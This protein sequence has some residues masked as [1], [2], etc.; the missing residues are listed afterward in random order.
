MLTGENEV[1]VELERVNGL[2]ICACFEMGTNMATF[3]GIVISSKVKEDAVEGNMEKKNLQGI[4]WG[5]GLLCE[6]MSSQ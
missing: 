3:W 5:L 1:V 6:L 4:E 2:E